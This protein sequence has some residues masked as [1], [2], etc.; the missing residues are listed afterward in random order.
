MSSKCLF[1]QESSLSR[2][3]FESDSSSTLQPALFTCKLLDVRETIMTKTAVSDRLKPFQCRWD[4]RGLEYPTWYIQLFMKPALIYW[5]NSQKRWDHLYIIWYHKIFW[6]VAIQRCCANFL[7]PLP[8]VARSL[9]DSK[10]IALD[11]TFSS[12]SIVKCFEL[13]LTLK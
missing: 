4:R 6:T 9:P 10:D 8:V 3:K 7:Q 13:C 5:C 2:L 1:V 12:F 11:F